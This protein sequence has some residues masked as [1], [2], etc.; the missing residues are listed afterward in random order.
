MRK[1]KFFL[2]FG[3]LNVLELH[4]D[5]HRKKTKIEVFSN[6]LEVSDLYDYFFRTNIFE[7]S[8]NNKKVTLKIWY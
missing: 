2:I 7:A 1:V 5:E 4:V 3:G 8:G 6:S